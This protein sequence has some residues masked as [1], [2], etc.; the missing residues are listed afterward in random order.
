[1]KVPYADETTPVGAIPT[2]LPRAEVYNR[3]VATLEDVVASF[4]ADQKPVYGFVGLD[5]AESVLAKIYLNAGVFTGTPAYDKCYQ[6]SKA[7]IDRL[8]KGG[9]YGNGLVR[10]YNA[11]FGANNDQYVVG[12]GGSDVNEIIWS[13]V[14]NN[15]NLTGFSGSNFMI[16]GW[17]GTNGVE[18]TMATPTDDEDLNGKFGYDADGNVDKIYKYYSSE[19]TVVY[20]ADKLED[21]QKEYG[22]DAKFGTVNV[23]G[24]DYLTVN[25]KAV[26]ALF[27]AEKDFN[28]LASDKKESYKT[29]V[30]E[31][32]NGVAYSFDPTQTGYMACD[33]Y[34]VNSDMAWKCMVARKSFVRKFEW[35]DVQMSKSAD[36]RVSLWQTSAHGFTPENISL[37]GDDWGK[38]GYIC[39]KYSNWAYEENG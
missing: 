36:R 6:H 28:K 37:V 14:S 8:G 19:P 17:V 39:P 26:S 27:D 30:S 32:V 38:N 11:I 13:I 5:M 16:A 12:N 18:P 33:W 9:Y 25:N 2:Q 7:V 21:Y 10:S 24:V 31:V 35:D 20:E 22:E 15:V 23:N 34:N 3:V 1:D 4:P 29:V